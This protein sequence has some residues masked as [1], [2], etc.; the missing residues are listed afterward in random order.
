MKIALHVL[1]YDVNRYIGPMLQNAAP[2]VDKIYL[3]YPSRPFGYISSSREQRTNPTQLEDIDLSGL[4]DKVEI[5][6]GD[7][8]FEEQTRNECLE[9]A[10]REGYDWLII[11]DADELYEDSS[12]ESLIATLRSQADI[13]LYRTTWF[14]FWKSGRYVLEF[15]NRTIKSA[16]V[17][18]ALRC[19]P[20]LH[21]VARRQSNATKEQTLD[22]PCFHYGYVKSDQ[23]ILEKL[24]TWSHADEVRNRNTWFRLKWE[25]WNLGTRNLSPTDPTGWHRAIEFPFLQPSFAEHFNLPV[26]PSKKLPLSVLLENRLFDARVETLS[27]LRRIKRRF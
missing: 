14:T 1:A 15:A 9:R 4:G 21:F 8:E 25:N 26:Q 19:L 11:Q 12:W 23:E 18:F 16:N 3:A 27:A 7:W 20:H 2:W 17:G 13:E 22:F 6:K 5:L 24:T 10:K